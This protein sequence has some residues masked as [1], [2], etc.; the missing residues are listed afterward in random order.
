MCK[1]VLRMYIGNIR[2]GVLMVVNANLMVICDTSHKN[3][4]RMFLKN[5]DIDVFLQD[6]MGSY[7]S[8]KVIIVFATIAHIWHIRK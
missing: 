1:S 3:G 2:F 8:K 4:S 7:P 6:Y 5:I